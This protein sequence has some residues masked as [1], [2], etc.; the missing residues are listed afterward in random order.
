MK[1]T[2]FIWLTDED[3]IL[4]NGISDIILFKG[5]DAG[6]GPFSIIGPTLTFK[7]LVEIPK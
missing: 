5:G 1:L 2:G 6:V 7:N 3:S 4:A